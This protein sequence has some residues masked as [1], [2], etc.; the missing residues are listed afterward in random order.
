[1]KYFYCSVIVS[2]FQIVSEMICS[3]NL[4][5]GDAVAAIVGRNDDV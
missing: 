4:Y 3:S 5:A 2:H 1:M